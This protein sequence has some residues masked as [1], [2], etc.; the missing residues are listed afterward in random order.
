MLNYKTT[1]TDFLVS[2]NPAA[3]AK[4]INS[5][6]SQFDVVFDKAYV[7]DEKARSIKLEVLESEMYFNSRNIDSVRYN[8]HRIRIDGPNELT[9][10]VQSAI[11]VI[12]NGLYEPASLN[13][14]LQLLLNNAGF[15][16]NMIAITGNDPINRIQITFN[17]VNASVH[18]NN[19]DYHGFADLL[20]FNYNVIAPAVAGEIK[21][22]P[23]LATFNKVNYYIITSNI[24][25][26]ATIINGQSSHAI[27]RI[28]ITGSANYQIQ[29]EP[30]YPYTFDITYLRG[31]SVRRLT[32]Q[33][34][35]DSG[36]LI[37]T[38]GETWSM[39]YRITYEY[40]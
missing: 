21:T 1:S 34:R 16:L 2:S 27:A 7:Y 5:L 14:S 8:N 24:T 32:F 12:P 28:L 4:N 40:N 38:L 18:F 22:A 20:G 10:V 37:D 15:K 3:G 29:N 9:G 13:N 17:Y 36:E 19:A 25:G 33:L 23:N 6:G 26:N 39:R 31:Q 30:A 35:D 11:I